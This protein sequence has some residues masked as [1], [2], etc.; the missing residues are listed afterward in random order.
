[1]NGKK[2]LNRLIKLFVV[3]NLVLFAFNYVSKSNEYLLSKDRVEQIT[4]LLENE[5]IKIEG[6]LIRDYSP[7]K[8]A[9]LLYKGDSLSIRDDIVKNLF[10]SD[11]A[12]VKRFKKDSEKYPSE[13][14]KC[15]ALNGETLTFDKY[16]LG[17]ENSNVSTSGPEL[18]LEQAKK[19]CVSL[20]NRLGMKINEAD[21]EVVSQKEN[22]GWQLAYYY[23]LEGVPV[24]DLYMQFEV[25]REGV[26]RAII[27]LGEVEI[28]SSEGKEIY[29]VDLVLFGL[30]E[31]LLENQYTSIESVSMIY[32]KL[33]DEESIWGQQIVPVYKIEI[34]GLEKLL[35]VNAYTNEILREGK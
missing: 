23:K 7:K 3:L 22:G 16:E 15:Y 6:A 5:G 32:K 34:S 17:Y 29:P 12:S 14:V 10:T 26:A 1:M 33:D 28:I 21:Y 24:Q 2:I 25:Y 9:N 31:E 18:N 20:M 35:F 13:E 8:Q 30:E 19:L 11:L 4:Q 27:Y